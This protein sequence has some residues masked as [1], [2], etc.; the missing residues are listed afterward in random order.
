MPSLYL[1]FIETIIY[2][3]SYMS[4]DFLLHCLIFRRW[5][6]VYG[7]VSN[8]KGLHEISALNV[9]LGGPTFCR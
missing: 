2:D 8:T 4:A 7:E 5:L 9:C 1:F 3:S 6:D